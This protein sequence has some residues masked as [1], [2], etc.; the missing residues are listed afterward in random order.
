MAWQLS[1][2]G[3]AKLCREKLTQI[4]YNHPSVE[5]MQLQA[6][7]KSGA[8]YV[9][10]VIK[11]WAEFRKSDSSSCRNRIKDGYPTV[12]ERG[13]IIGINENRKRKS[14]E[15]TYKIIIWF[16][17]IFFENWSELSRK[18]AVPSSGA[19]LET[20]LRFQN[21]GKNLNGN[22]ILPGKSLKF[23]IIYFAVNE[24]EKDEPERQL[25]RNMHLH[26]RHSVAF[27]L[28]NVHSVFSLTWKQEKSSR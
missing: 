26:S 15:N 18:G 9:P 11:L 2:L 28:N 3:K 24:A 10:R 5:Y 25:L 23:P 13:K 19:Y 1:D 6:H 27:T 22:W 4:L 20:M 17:R 12:Q 21:S 16:L 8:F 7:W 14:A